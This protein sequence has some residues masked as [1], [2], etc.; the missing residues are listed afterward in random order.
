MIGALVMSHPPPMPF[1]AAPT[2]SGHSVTAVFWV[3]IIA[4]LLNFLVAF[5][6][7]PES[8]EKARRKEQP[9]TDGNTLQT[10]SKDQKRGFIRSLITSLDV[11]A[12]KRKIYANGRVR[13]DWNMT[14]IALALFGYL[15][16]AV[17]SLLNP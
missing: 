1:V 11:F 4:Q 15:L 3:A 14:F 2:H 16:S 13:R 7:F 12:P 6:V 8:L 17:S 5:C 10:F 9:S